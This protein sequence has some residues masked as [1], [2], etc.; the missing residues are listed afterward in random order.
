MIRTHP[1]LHAW[2][3]HHPLPRRIAAAI[4]AEL[5]VLST[6]TLVRDIQRRFGCAQCTAF[7][8]LRIA[9]EELAA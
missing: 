3:R 1:P 8:A 2:T 4:P 6:M 5:L 7:H 9:R